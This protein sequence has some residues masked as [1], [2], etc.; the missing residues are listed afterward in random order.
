MCSSDLQASAWS[1]PAWFEVEL[2]QAS[3]WRATWIGLGRIRLNFKPP[4]SLSP[5]DPVARALGPVPY[6]RRAFTVDRPVTSARLHVTALGLYEARLN[7]HRIG[8]AVLA[9]GWTDY[10]RRIPYQT[11]DVTGL[12]AGGENVLAALLADGWYSGFIGFDA[13]RAGAQYGP[14]PEFL[15]QLV[16]RFADGSD[17]WIVTDGRWRAAFGAIRHADLLMGERHDLALEPH[18]WDS[19]GFDTDGWLDVRCRDRDDVP[20]VADPGPPVR[21]TQEVPAVSIAADPAGRQIVDF[22]QNLPGWVRISVD[23]PPGACIRGIGRAH[24]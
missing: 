2:D 14:A 13:K 6:L 21:V 10:T 23:G 9:P 8:D 24:V 5:S 17:Q 18:G 4:T 7:G 19:P 22:G 15:A 11:Y 3:G 12:L 1:E 20:L 16:I